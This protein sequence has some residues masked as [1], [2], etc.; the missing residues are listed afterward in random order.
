ML[1]VLNP[2]GTLLFTDIVN[3]AEYS[4]QFALMNTNNIQLI[5]FFHLKIVFCALFHSV[6]MAPQQYRPIKPK[7]I[8]ILH[9]SGLDVVLNSA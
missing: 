9:N 3:R 8:S 5:I 6:L 2:N 4:E 7:F 1:R